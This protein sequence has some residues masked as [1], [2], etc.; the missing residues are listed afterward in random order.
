MRPQRLNPLFQSVGTVKGIGPKS[1]AALKRLSGEAVVDLLFHLPYSVVERREI[2]QAADVEDGA[3]VIMTVTIER[4]A[5]PDRPGRPW[6]VHCLDAAGMPVEIVFF[7]SHGDYLQRQLPTGARRT[8]SGRLER[9]RG[10]PQIAHPDYIERPENSGRIPRLEP[11]YPLTANLTNGQLIKALNAALDF[12]PELGEWL[13]PALV[14]RE[15]WPAW[16]D[17]LL[18]IHKPAPDSEDRRAEARRRLSYDEL[19]ANQ[20][21]LALLR[22]H[23]KQQR[24]RALAGTGALIETAMTTLPFALTGSQQKALADIRHDMADSARMLR[25][26]QGDVGSGKTVV[27]LIAMLQ[28]VESGTQ[29]AMMAPTEILAR[30]H[31]DTLIG[32]LRALNVRVE[33]LTGR[34][35]GR[36][37]QNL[38]EDLAA[39]RIDILVGTHAVFQ[40]D[41]EFKDLG[42]AVIDEQHRFGVHE[43]LS[44]QRKGVAAD[45]LVMTATP[46]P[47]TLALTAYGDLDVSR[48]LDKPPGRIPVDTRVM[49]TDRLADVTQA[50]GRKIDDG[51]RV[52]WIC[53]L[54]EESEKSDM[55]AAEDRYAALKT[56]FGDRV[57]LVHGRL[58]APEKDSVMAAFADGRIDI[59]VATTVVEVG[60]NVPE[61]TVMVIEQAE[62]F[63]LAQLHQ[64]RG[65]IGRG[66]DASTCLLLYR[67]P[68]TE[69]AEARLRIMRETEDGFRIAEEDLRLRGSGEV[70]GTR[71]SGLPSFKLADLGQDG[72]L[73]AMASDDARLIIARDP[74]L[75]TPR[76]AAIREL[77]YLFRRDEAIRYLRSG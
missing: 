31:F 20:L 15:N 70:L 3:N 55:A 57:G 22:Q 5:S 18:M 45:L 69:T 50:V 77:L 25:L 51:A 76:G 42:L 56:I 10:Q 61:A 66:T 39:G 72:E 4:H 67:P 14:Q 74:D 2:A 68:L 7:R 33:V 26:L 11:V 13:D 29:A 12:L 30:Q 16:R 36:E 19:L 46:I 62:R 54:V 58:K 24:G 38:L 64:L 34:N 44:L 48:L 17:A 27:A 71:Q 41:I 47:R 73:L 43:R 40:K 28:A 65:R 53:P 8:L 35:K 60:V 59:L 6:R 21:A 75:K 37:R 63:G 52:F 1:I 23:Q 32:P 9:Y 49:S